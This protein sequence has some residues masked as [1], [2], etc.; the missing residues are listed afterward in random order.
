M[1]SPPLTSM[2]RS[3]RQKISKEPLALNDTSEQMDLADRYRTFYPKETEYTFFS[4][5][6]ATFSR[7]DH[8][9]GHKISLNKLKRTEII[10]S[11][12]PIHNDMKLKINYMKKIGKFTNMW[13]LNNMLL[14]NKWVKEEIKNTLRASLVAQ[15]LRICLLMQGTRV[16]ALVWEDP[17]CRGAAGPVSHSC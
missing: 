1:E 17:T 12:S 14:N 7:I 3:S 6:Y 13:R 4:T 16:R 2:D 5:A 10:S 11:I 15:W 8:M 9:L